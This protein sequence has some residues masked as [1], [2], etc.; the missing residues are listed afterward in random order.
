MLPPLESLLISKLHMA[1]ASGPV[2][3]SAITPDLPGAVRE[4]LRSLGLPH[5]LAR[6]PLAS[7]QGI[8]Q[9]AASVRGLIREAVE[10]AFGETA[11]ERLLHRVLVRGYLDPA[12]S[13]EQAAV[14]LHLSRSTY[15]RRLKA[16][17]DRVADYVAANLELM[18][19]ADWR[20]GAGIT[21]G[22]RTS[23]AASIRW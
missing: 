12:S 20:G 3:P 5:A 13:H 9:R 4:A 21:D 15:F 16:A 2:P 14:E 17:S 7:G 18:T 6:S 8:A 22:S 11:D 1:L 23:R 10:D 19:A